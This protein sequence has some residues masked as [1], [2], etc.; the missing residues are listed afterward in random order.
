MP[1]NDTPTTPASPTATIARIAVGSL[2][3]AALGFGAYEL[4]TLTRPGDPLN[5]ALWLAGAVALHD[6]LLV[7]LVLGAGLFV[8]RSRSR[9]ALRGGL[10]TAGCLTLL[11]LP[12]ML[13]PG[14]PNNPTVL[15][16]D[17]PVN[18]ALALLLT[19]LAT[20]CVARATRPRRKVRAP[21]PPPPPAME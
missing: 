10:L 9:T 16:L 21:A 13:R 15:P 3:V 5:V 7:P 17:Y 14:K 4:L 6:G 12:L 20:A 11:A 19:A 1:R 18:W 2:G 8:G